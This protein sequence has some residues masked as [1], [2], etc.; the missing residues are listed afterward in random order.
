IKLTQDFPKYSA[1][2]AAH[3]A[4][5]EF[6]EEQRANLGRMI[7]SGV[8]VLW[9]NG[10]QLVERLIEPFSLVD[11]LRRERRLI[12][13]V[14][15]V[16]LT[17]SEAILLLSHSS[18][19]SAKMT[20]SSQRFDWRDDNEGGDAI[21][22]LND[23]ENDPA[24][25]DMPT[26]VRAVSCRSESRNTSPRSMKLTLY[27]LFSSSSGHSPAKCPLSD[28]TSSTSWSRSTSQRRWI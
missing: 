8:N 28:A 3:D 12:S 1:L 7:P 20:D 11:M 10:V 16:G 13:E 18:V 4:S 6:I 17:G 22:W 9:M 23:L 24:F 21:M 19:T 26:N 27:A 25:E 14:K 5:A 2:M 15:D